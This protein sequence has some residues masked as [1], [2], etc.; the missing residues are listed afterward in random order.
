MLQIPSV[1]VF[2]SSF[3]SWFN[4]YECQI[5]T[6]FQKSK[7]MKTYTQRRAP[8]FHISCIPFF[9]PCSN[10]L[11]CFCFVLSCD[12]KDKQM[13]V[14]SYFLCF[15]NEGNGTGCDFLCF[16]LFIY[17]STSQDLLDIIPH[18]FVEHF[19]IVFLQRGSIYCTFVLE[20]IQWFLML[21]RLG[22][23]QYF[24]VTDN[25]TMNWWWDCWFQG[26]MWIQFC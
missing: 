26:Q 19:L 11:N 3:P 7:L 10:Q 25:S 21:G 22:S 15:L 12:F 1:L 2:P 17:F 4:S 13:H 23:F 6:C 9:T 24:A 5:L 20:F 8:L 14:F 16:V 18:H